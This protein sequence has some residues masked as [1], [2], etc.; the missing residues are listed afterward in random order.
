MRG[1]LMISTLAM[2]I[3]AAACG[4]SDDP[5]APTDA[6]GGDRPSSTGTVTIV[7]PASGDVIEGTSVE[8]RVELDDARIVPQTTR[9]ISPDEGHLHVY[10]DGS[11]I[12]MTEGTE[13]EVTDLTPG[14][15]RIQVEFVAAD[16]APFDPRVVT[17]AAFQVRA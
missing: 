4:A 5:P 8:L 2:A 13:Q 3:V 17:I 11:L 15:H 14:P 7:S 10:L 12:S 16:H 6:T 1:A 9:E